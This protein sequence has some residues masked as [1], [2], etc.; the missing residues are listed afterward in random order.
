VSA[1]LLDQIA[2]QAAQAR[3]L[4]L[5]RGDVDELVEPALFQRR[6]EP[7]AGPFDRVFPRRVE[8]FGGVGGGGRELPVVGAV[9][10]RFP[11]FANGFAR[12]FA[13]EHVVLVHRHVL[14]QAAEGQR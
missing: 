2:Q 7:H 11:R 14:E 12:Q 6:V 9:P 4:S 8:L 3:V 1:V 10:Q 5:S 13:S